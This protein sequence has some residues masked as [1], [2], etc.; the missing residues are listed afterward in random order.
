MARRYHWPCRPLASPNVRNGWEAD[1][2]DAVI[3]PYDRSMRSILLAIVSASLV[4][5][6]DSGRSAL[7]AGNGSPL[8]HPGTITLPTVAS[9]P[10]REALL[11]FHPK[12]HGGSV[13]AGYADLD[14]LALV[15]QQ[16]TDCRVISEHPTG[17]GFGAAA[18]SLSGLVL[19]FPAADDGNPIE[20]RIR[21]RITFP[22]QN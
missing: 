2:G 6:A 3:H 4:S 16:V 10:T 12:S 5:C 18:S 8:R 11:A 17:Q 21:F 14:C 7:E 9:L 22:G 19:V 15:N 13:T 1:I 20:Q